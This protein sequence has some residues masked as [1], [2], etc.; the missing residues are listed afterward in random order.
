MEFGAGSCRV[1]LAG[2]AVSARK[3][4]ARFNGP[5][6]EQEGKPGRHQDAEWRP[7]RMKPG[8]QR[9]LVENLRDAG[10][11]PLEVVPVEPD[12]KSAFHL[13][14]G[15][16]IPTCPFDA[17]QPVNRKGADPEGEFEIAARGIQLGALDLRLPGRR[18]ERLK[19]LRQG[20]KGPDVI[21][22]CLDTEGPL[23]GEYP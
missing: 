8:P 10:R 5:V 23:E 20:V 6:P 16:R 21:K 11:H 15:E 17:G 13:I 19:G 18:R 22:R 7:E 12:L 9:H 2:H 3:N 14:V 1:R 4:S